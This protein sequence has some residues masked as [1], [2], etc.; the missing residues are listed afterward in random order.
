MKIGKHDITLKNI[1]AYLQGNL[2][3]LAEDYGPDFIKMRQH[4]REQVMFRNDIANPDCI[5]ASKC[6]E[7]HC[8]IPG[9]FYA[10][11]QCG[12]EC[13]PEMMDEHT[14]DKFKK[15]LRIYTIENK[16][17]DVKYP[18]D[19][20]AVMNMIEEDEAIES[21]LKEVFDENDT[22]IPN[23]EYDAGEV[24]RG[25]N[26]E[27]TFTLENPGNVNMYIA[28]VHKTCS[29]TTTEELINKII[30]AGESIDI[31]LTINT[32]NKPVGTEHYIITQLVMNN[33]TKTNLAI[34]FKIH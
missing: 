10:N 16:I 20:D 31:T 13:Y 30:P 21:H 12:G 22:Q 17:E 28:D 34:K 14:W 5:N 9:L 7:C 32:K 25:V 26:I 18:F 15:A 8:D 3:K 6:Q 4:I 2:R 1:E 24:K 29:C 11:K 23:Q 33:H 27:K 19:W